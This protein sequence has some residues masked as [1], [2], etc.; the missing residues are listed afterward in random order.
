M[1]QAAASGKILH[2]WW[3]PHNFGRDTELNTS[4]L[5]RLLRVFAECRDRFGFRSMS[6][7][8]AA[9]AAQ[10]ESQMPE[11]DLIGTPL[12]SRP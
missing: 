10:G 5:R 8:G 1:E 4:G 6:M 7:A 9:S 11:S 12:V 2:L 3:H